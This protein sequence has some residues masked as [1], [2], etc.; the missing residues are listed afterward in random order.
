MKF[1]LVI[2]IGV[3]AIVLLM[4][5]LTSRR[6]NEKADF[7][8]SRVP[9][10]S[11]EKGY[12]DVNGL[13]IYYEVHGAGQPLVLLHGS[14]M[15]IDL[16]FGQIIPYFA[17]TRKV[18]AL[19]QQAHGHTGDLGRPLSYKQMAD[20]TAELLKQLE[21]SNADVIGYS[22]G[23][24]TAIFLAFRHPEI[25]RKLVILS[26]PFNREGWYPE[27]YDSIKQITPEAFAGSGLPET[28]EAVSPNP[29]GWAVLVEKIKSLEADFQGITPEEFQS[30][31]APALILIGHSD[32]VPPGKAV[33]MFTLSGG[34][35]FGDIAGLPDSQLAIIPGT[36]HVGIMQQAQWW[37]PMVSAFLDKPLG[38]E[39]K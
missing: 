36:S 25:V 18:I 15:T 29:D 4:V 7:H 17:G 38:S 31:K 10:I 8:E 3:V 16:N 12:K 19:E 35:V 27:V 1:M 23:G 14:F 32:G 34:G 21:I 28:Y 30:I 13:N 11:V 26:S 5:F 2:L 9:M 37:L 33:D 6:G 20:D 39:G 22:M 24:T